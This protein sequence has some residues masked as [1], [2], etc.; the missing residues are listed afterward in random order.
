M[1]NHG[2][3]VF[4][5]EKNLD[6]PRADRPTWEMIAPATPAMS[7]QF[8]STVSH[9][10]PFGFYW[11]G[12]KHIEATGIDSRAAGEVPCLQEPKALE[13]LDVVWYQ[14]ELYVAGW[15]PRLGPV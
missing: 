12:L 1:T 14:K 6:N 13:M 15:E 5:P 3:L 4:F 7:W 10:G 2:M 11:W 9:W 8:G